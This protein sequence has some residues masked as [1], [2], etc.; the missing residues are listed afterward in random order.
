MSECCGVVKIVLL[1]ASEAETIL[2]FH[3][4][5]NPDIPTI[6]GRP[7]ERLF[8]EMANGSL[9]VQLDESTQTVSLARARNAIA[10]FHDRFEDDSTKN[11]EDT[12]NPLDVK[13]GKDPS[14]VQIQ[15]AR[16]LVI[17]ASTRP[18]VPPLPPDPP[19]ETSIMDAMEKKWLTRVENF[20]EALWISSPS[21]IIPCSI[22]GITVEA[23]LNPVMEVN[24]IPWHLA[25]TLFDNVTLRPSDKLLK[26]CLSG[27]IRKFRGVAYDVPL[28]VNKININTSTSLMSSILISS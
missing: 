8:Q 1:V 22:K 26:S 10:K 21:T 12:L 17:E 13:Q 5:D 3:V 2:D 7:I 4:Y 18:T 24:I 11:P 20:S 28:I 27:H 14:S 6:I 15:P 25:Y 19:T 16:N 23:H 9:D